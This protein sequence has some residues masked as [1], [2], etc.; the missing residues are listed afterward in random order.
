MEKPVPTIPAEFLARLLAYRWPGN[1]RELMNVMERASILATDGVLPVRA[2]NQL[3]HPSASVGASKPL[4]DSVP[5]PDTTRGDR[6]EDID[7]RH[8]LA[9][10]EST[11]WIVGGSRGAAARLGIKRPTLIYRMKR[12]GIAR[13][14]RED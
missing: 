6:L 9:V 10:L 8:I 11:N 3:S 13:S 14:R 1:I 5:R 2:L 7:R 4:E 12:L